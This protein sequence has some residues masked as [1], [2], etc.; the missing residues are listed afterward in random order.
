MSEEDTRMSDEDVESNDGRK[1]QSTTR[2][3]TTRQPTTSQSGKDKRS[4]DARSGGRVRGA[5][6]WSLS[7]LLIALAASAGVAYLYVEQQRISEQFIDLARGW[8]AVDETRAAQASAHQLNDATRVEVRDLTSRMV[9]VEDY[10]RTGDRDTL[11]AE[12]DAVL[13][14]QLSEVRE[15][16]GPSREDWLLAEAEYLL[17]LASQR[18]LMDR[19]VPSAI[20]LIQTVD[21]ILADAHGLTVFEL[22]ASLAEDLAA[23]GAVADL[24]TEG[25]FLR[26][27]ALIGRVD[28]LR[29]QQL[30]Y[31][32]DVE[33]VPEVSDPGA[34][35]LGNLTSMLGSAGSRIAALV[36]YRVS[37]ERVQP[38]LPAEEEYY[39][40]QNLVMK[41]QQAQLA[42]LSGKQEIFVTSIGDARN[43]INRYFDGQDVETSSVLITLAELESIDTTREIPDISVSLRLVRELQRR[44]ESTR[45]ESENGV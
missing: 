26:L 43:W 24:D 11:L 9:Q 2:Q 1:S 20:A 14:A 36:D 21:D 10:L 32:M 44:G 19:D 37:D 38:V 22:R 15:L 16:V 40:R 17:R 42:L 30:I 35:V 5:P 25:I 3:P 6:I 39:L 45:G 18:L 13:S 29:Q 28:V 4:R 27:N 8:T 34:T 12:V 23:L 31:Q 7:A 41:Y 33:A